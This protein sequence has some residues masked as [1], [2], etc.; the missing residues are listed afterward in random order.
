M[1]SGRGARAA[2]DAQAATVGALALGL[3]AAVLL[4]ARDTRRRVEAARK[5]TRA[6]T[7]SRDPRAGFCQAALEVTRA[8]RAFLLEPT[9]NE[10]ALGIRAAAGLPMR[11]EVPGG[12]IGPSV[13]VQ[14]FTSG[15]T[16]I[17]RDVRRDPRASARLVSATDAR[18]VLAQPLRH[19]DRVLGVLVLTWSHR[20]RLTDEE[21]AAIELLAAAAALALERSRL[22][23]EAQRAA[24]TDPLTE[25]ANRRVWDRALPRELARAERL[26][27]PLSVALLDLDHFKRFND[28]HG[29]QAGD[30]LLVDATRAWAATLRTIDLL[31]R[32]GG[33]E[34]ALLLPGAGV[35]EALEAVERVRSRTP[36]GQRAS[37]GVAVWDGRE[38]AEHLL[39]RADRALYAAKDAGRDRVGVDDPERGRWV[40]EAP[41]G[42]A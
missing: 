5:V 17:V 27:V 26:G 19:G 28:T 23:A 21:I 3:A 8:E 31:A 41:V 2:P 20:L 33:E 14:A 10:R 38:T 35:D 32:Y 15:R 6:L 24:R 34:F 25:V 13:A 40:T 4:R 1:P 39:G 18:A 36:R 22:L 12:P 11:T 30:R 9:G 29:H 7:G 37:A 42:G 16:A